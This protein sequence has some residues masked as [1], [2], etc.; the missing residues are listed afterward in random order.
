MNARHL[1]DIKAKYYLEAILLCS[2]VMREYLINYA[3]SLIYTTALG[4]PTLAMIKSAYKLMQ[5]DVTRAAQENLWALIQYFHSSLGKLPT[6]RQTYPPRKLP[7]SPIFS[8]CTAH[9]RSLAKYCQNNGLVV[10]PIV[11]P[12]VPEGTSRVRVCLHAGNT[13]EEVDKLC[14][15]I[16]AW[17]DLQCSAP[18]ATEVDGLV[19]RL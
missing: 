9:P 12:T 6:T 11:P 10:R 18:A 14:R 16:S 7:A 15:N 13:T 8:I 3:R 17:I 4:L 5:S 19:S 1:N 2:P